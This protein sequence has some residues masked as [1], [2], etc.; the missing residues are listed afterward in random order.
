[1]VIHKFNK[2][3]QLE[4]ESQKVVFKAMMSQNENGKDINKDKTGVFVYQ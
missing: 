4:T 1:M 2:V 3:L